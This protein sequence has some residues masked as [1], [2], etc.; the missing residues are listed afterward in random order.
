[1]SFHIHD[2]V[3]EFPICEECHKPKLEN[4]QVWASPGDG[5]CFV[6]CL[7]KVID[8]DYDTDPAE[9]ARNFRHRVRKVLTK[10]SRKTGKI[11]YDDYR[12]GILS[13]L[14]EEYT[15]NAMSD[16]F[17]SAQP[18]DHV[19][20]LLISYLTGIKFHMLHYE[21]GKLYPYHSDPRNGNIIFIY[22]EKG[23]HFDLCHRGSTFLFKQEDP[24]LHYLLQDQKP[25]H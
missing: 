3:V 9:R 14:S 13:Q 16:R 8:P 22:Y 24:V 10:V 17:D 21:T 19:D 20:I 2:Q 6:H 11:F 25:H 7:L 4:L 23:Q 5:H 1:M 18:L 12:D 15:L